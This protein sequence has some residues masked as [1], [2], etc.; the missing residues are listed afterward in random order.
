LGT[1]F[2]G[3]GGKVLT[4]AGGAALGYTVADFIQSLLGPQ[5]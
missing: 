1:G 2:K 3:T 5:Q 4:G